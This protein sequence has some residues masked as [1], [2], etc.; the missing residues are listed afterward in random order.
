MTNSSAANQQHEPI[1]LADLCARKA[2][3]KRAR[4][5]SWVEYGVTQIFKHFSLGRRRATGEKNV[6]PRGSYRRGGEQGES[7]FIIRRWKYIALTIR[8]M[9]V[10]WV[11]YLAFS[12]RNGAAIVAD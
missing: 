11:S 8:R 5:I 1:L 10:F 12:R 6:V 2:I 7:F 4:D 3:L 9:I